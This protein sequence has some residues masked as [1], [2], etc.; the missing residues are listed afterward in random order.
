MAAVTPYGRFKS[1]L[2]LYLACMSALFL[3][4]ENFV[5]RL[6]SSGLYAIKPAPGLL[7]LPSTQSLQELSKNPDCILFL[8]FNFS[9]DHLIADLL[10]P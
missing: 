5:S 7:P 8:Q 2:G 6:L 1:F 4:R 3:F 9:K 10:S